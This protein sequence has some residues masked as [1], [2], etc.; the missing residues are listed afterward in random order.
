LTPSN[1]PVLVET[2]LAGGARKSNTVRGRA[3]LVSPL[4][5]RERVARMGRVRGL[6][7]SEPLYPLIRS[8]RDHLL[9]LGEKETTHAKTLRRLAARRFMRGRGAERRFRINKVRLAA[10]RCGGFGPHSLAL[11]PGERYGA[12]RHCGWCCAAPLALVKAS[13]PIAG[14]YG[15]LTAA[16]PSFEGSGEAVENLL[17]RAHQAR[18]R[19]PALS[20]MVR[21]A[22]R[23]S[24]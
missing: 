17:S 21:Y 3:Q 11:G 2:A 22:H 5:V 16:E 7:I 8:L 6:G 10:P 23:T 13:L 4:P 1:D 15:R 14:L 12:T 9:P 19:T 20:P 18:P 24:H